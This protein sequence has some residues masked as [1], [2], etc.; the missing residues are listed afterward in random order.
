[1]TD[2]G[3]SQWRNWCHL[4]TCLPIQRDRSLMQVLCPTQ[5]LDKTVCPGR[6]ANKQANFA[7]PEYVVILWEKMLHLYLWQVV[8]EMLADL[9]GQN[10]KSVRSARKHGRLRQRLYPRTTLSPIQ[11]SMLEMLPL[12]FT[13]KKSVL[14]PYPGTCEPQTNLFVH[15]CRPAMLSCPCRAT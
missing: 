10:S 6:T 3:E 14:Q 12:Q 5:E 15:Q 9:R 7:D 2:E 8:L 13:S 11:M 1:M 4:L